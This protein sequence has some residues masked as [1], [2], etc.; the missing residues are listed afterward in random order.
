[1]PGHEFHNF[2][3]GRNIPDFITELP[4]GIAFGIADGLIIHS[5]GTFISMPI[6][7]LLSSVKEISTMFMQPINLFRPP[8]KLTLTS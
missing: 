4:P 7:I 3:H 2:G 5:E 1:M 6:T 8:R